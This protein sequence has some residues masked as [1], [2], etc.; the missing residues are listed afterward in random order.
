[1]FLIGQTQS[2]QKSPSLKDNQ[3][4]INIWRWKRSLYAKDYP[5]HQLKNDLIWVG[6]VTF[7][8]AVFFCSEFGSIRPIMYFKVNIVN[9]ASTEYFTV[10]AIISVLVKLSL[11]IARRI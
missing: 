5:G 2:F 1:M 7:L 10:A 11:M 8:Y 9:A 4:Y 3:I 6:Y